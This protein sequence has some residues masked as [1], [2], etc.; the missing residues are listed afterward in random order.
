MTTEHLQ[1]AGLS[2]CVGQREITNLSFSA[3]CGET[4]GMLPT[5]SLMYCS[6]KKAYKPKNTSVKVSGRVEQIYPEKD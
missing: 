6:I 3:A 1:K 4:K 5:P 2:L